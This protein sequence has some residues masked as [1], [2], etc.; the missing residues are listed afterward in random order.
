MI[1][2]YISYITKDNFFLIFYIAHFAI[3]TKNNIQGGFQDTRLLLFV[4]KKVIS[5]LD[6]KLY[7]LTPENSCPGTA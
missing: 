5:I 3:I 4:P 6:L 2:A 7:I 1:Q